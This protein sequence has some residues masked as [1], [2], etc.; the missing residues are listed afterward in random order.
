LRSRGETLAYSAEEIGWKLRNLNIPRHTSSAGRHVLLGRETSRG[1]HRLARAYDLP[2]PKRGGE[3]C[4][5]CSQE[6]AAHSK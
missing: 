3:I 6:K 5:D 4:P 2:C 1:V